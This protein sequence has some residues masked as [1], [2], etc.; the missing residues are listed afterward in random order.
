MEAGR[1]SVII[2]ISIESYS[3]RC[4][5]S[6]SGWNRLVPPLYV[7]Q[8]RGW[9]QCY[10]AFSYPLNDLKKGIFYQKQFF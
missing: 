1:L 7:R 6:R 8:K 3:Q 4:L 2:L 9:N 10:K 5:L